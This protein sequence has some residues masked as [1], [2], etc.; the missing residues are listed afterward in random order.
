MIRIIYILSLMSDKLETNDLY[1]PDDQR[2]YDVCTKQNQ[3]LREI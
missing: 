1:L 2:K 3:T